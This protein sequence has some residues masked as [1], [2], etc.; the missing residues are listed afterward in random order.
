[1]HTYTL[2]LKLLM[3]YNIIPIIELVFKSPRIMP[4]SIQMKGIFKLTLFMSKTRYV[5]R[6]MEAFHK[7]NMVEFVLQRYRIR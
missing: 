1:M 3:A 5:Q 6:V 7:S 4:V 2:T